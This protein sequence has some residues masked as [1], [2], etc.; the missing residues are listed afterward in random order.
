MIFFVF[1]KCSAPFTGFSVRFQVTSELIYIKLLESVPSIRREKRSRISYFHRFDDFRGRQM[2]E[3]RYV[4]HDL[5]S[6]V[7]FIS[8][9]P[10]PRACNF[11]SILGRVVRIPNETYIRPNKSNIFSIARVMFSSLLQPICLSTLSIYVTSRSNVFTNTGRHF[12]RFLRGTV[13][14]FP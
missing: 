11:F 8:P 1:R 6:V 7:Y 10:S 3:A 4:V 5:R 2:P 12:M 13:T 9:T 14:G